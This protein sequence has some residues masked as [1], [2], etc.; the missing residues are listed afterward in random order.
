MSMTAELGP[1][2]F[3]AHSFSEVQEIRTT[4]STGPCDPERY[5]L[6]LIGAKAL[7]L[8]EDDEASRAGTGVLMLHDAWLPHGFRAMSGVDRGKIIMLRFPK[9]ALPLRP[10]GLEPLFAR[11]LPTD[12]GMGAVLAHYLTSVASALEKGEVGE[13]EGTQLGKVALDLTVA[14]LTA[15]AGVDDVAAAAETRRQGLLSTIDTFIDHHLGNPELT[16]SMVAGHCHISLGHLHRLFQTRDLTIAAWIRHR[17]LECCRAD[18]A[19]PS[20]RSWPVHAIGARWGFRSAAEFSRA[21]RA[22]Y[23]SAPGR[24]RND[25]YQDTVSV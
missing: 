2:G 13:R 11:R 9:T 8:G 15:W 24:Y 12:A 21:F 19:D 6:S 17:R 20:L 14:T 22:A 25:G 4:V 23:G 7:P 10:R 3:S 16:P 5:Q 1:V 18:L